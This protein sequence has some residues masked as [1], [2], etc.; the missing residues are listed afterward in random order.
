MLIARGAA[1]EL[2]NAAGLTARMMATLRGRADLVALLV[3]R[4]ADLNAISPDGATAF[5]L[6]VEEDQ[7][8]LARLLMPRPAVVRAE[9]L[10]HR[11]GPYR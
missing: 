9:L 2:R 4:G 6:A 11:A 1:L 8:E 5:T 3:E 7:Q 10:C